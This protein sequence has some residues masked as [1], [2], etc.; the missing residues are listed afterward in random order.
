WLHSAR[1]R[2]ASE[3]QG[4]H[5][6]RPPHRHG[7]RGARGLT[8]GGA[9]DRVAGD[10]GRILPRLLGDGAGAG[11]KTVVSRRERGLII[12]IDGPAGSGKSSTARAV[13]TELGYLHLDSGAFYRALTLA[14]LEA[15][16]SPERWPSL[17]GD[18]L[19]SLGVEWK[20]TDDGIRLRV[21]GR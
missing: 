7:L 8:R 4:P 1:Q 19:R 13:A 10:R 2:P 18:D 12:A 21:R 17:D 20:V 3:G 11:R 16:I 9:G 14:A 6:P 15:G 5:L